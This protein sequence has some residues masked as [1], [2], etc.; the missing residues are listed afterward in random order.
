[1]EIADDLKEVYAALPEVERQS[2]RSFLEKTSS[3]KN[4]KAEFKSIAEAMVQ[5][6]LSSLKNKYS[7]T[8]ELKPD[9]L[10]P[11][12]SEAGII[13]SDVTEAIRQEDSL[14][15]KN[16]GDLSDEDVPKVIQLIKQITERL[17]KNMLRRYSASNYSRDTPGN[18]I[19][20]QLYFF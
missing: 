1:M 3:G 12:F 15:H 10:Q 8:I 4:V 11:V 5:A 16:L 9:I 13:A 14:L 20:R 2:I 19:C 17:R 7:G 6:K 18:G